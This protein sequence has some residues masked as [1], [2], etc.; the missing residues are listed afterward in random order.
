MNDNLKLK[1][2]SSEEEN[3]EEKS[4]KDFLTEIKKQAREEYFAE[5]G[6]K[7]IP[8]MENMSPKEAELYSEN[9]RR[10]NK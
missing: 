6:Y 5:E 4:F 7:S 10:N 3:K 9:L 1:D 8:G 2:K